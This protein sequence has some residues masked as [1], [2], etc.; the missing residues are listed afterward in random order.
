[1]RR[2]GFGI[3]LVDHTARAAFVEAWLTCGVRLRFSSAHFQRC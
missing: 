2:N 1:M 3:N